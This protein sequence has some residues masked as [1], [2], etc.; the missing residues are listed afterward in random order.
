M[1]QRKPQDSVA[2]TP[3]ARAL[4]TQYRAE[5]GKRAILS[6]ALV[7]FS[8]LTDDGRR[9]LIRQANLEEPRAKRRP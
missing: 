3:Q 8:R 1:A 2:L 6:A 9:E 4:L 5:W 7:A